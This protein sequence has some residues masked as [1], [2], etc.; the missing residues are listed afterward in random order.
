[1]RNL[2]KKVERHMQVHFTVPQGSWIGLT[3]ED[4]AYCRSLADA[5]H[6][7]HKAKGEDNPTRIT[8]GVKSRAHLNLVGVLGEYAFAKLLGLDP[9]IDKGQLPCNAN[10]DYDF[11]G[12]IDVKTT[13]TSN[14]KW[15][16]LKVR[17]GISRPAPLYALMQLAPDFGDTTLTTRV[18]FLGVLPKPLNDPSYALYFTPEGIQ[19]PVSELTH[20]TLEKSED[21]RFFISPRPI[22][23]KLHC[24]CHACKSYFSATNPPLSPPKVDGECDDS[25][26]KQESTQN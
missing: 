17:S 16:L 10:E 26:C 18:T 5:L 15:T 14:P 13:A 24:G 7:P 3:Q 4:V 6:E 12:F 22:W 9:P 8:G 2:Y 21:G 25:T 23:P 19:I 11:C 20:L 1:M